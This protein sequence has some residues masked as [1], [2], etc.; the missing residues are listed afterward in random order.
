[1]ITK[2]QAS[3]RGWLVRTRIRIDL[4]G[5]LCR[6]W[7]RHKKCRAMVTVKAILAKKTRRKKTRHSTNGVVDE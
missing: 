5:V 7:V 2:L 6:Y 4:Y 3:I 1:V